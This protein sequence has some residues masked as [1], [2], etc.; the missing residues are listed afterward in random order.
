[1]SFDPDALPDVAIKVANLSKV[2]PIYERPHDRILQSIMPRL[3]KLAGIEVK[4]YHRAFKALDQVS[5]EVRRGQALGIIGRNGSG[6]STLLQ[7]ICGTLQPT[8]GGVELHG[9]VAALLELG[10]GFNP[11]FT[12]RENIHMSAAVLGMTADEIAGVYEDIVEFSGIDPVFIEQPVKIYSSGMYV[13]LAFAVIAHVNADVLVIDEALAVGDAVF[14]QKCMRFL[15]AFRERGTLLFVSH[16]TGSVINFCDSAVWLDRGEMRMAGDA[17]GVANAYLEYCAQQS[18]GESVKIRSIKRPASEVK[19]SRRVDE[20][21]KFAL[22]DNIANSDGWTSDHA[23]ILSAILTADDGSVLKVA[24]GGERVRLTIT[25]KAHG[26]I[27][28]PIIGFFVKDRLGQSLFGDNTF[29]HMP[30][31]LQVSAEEV[32]R[33]DFLF[34]LPM[35]PDGDYSMTVA[36]AE[37]DP[38]VNV[39]HHWVHDA[40]VIKVASTKLRY[41]LVGIPF[42]AV[43]MKVVE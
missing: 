37:G 42:E 41:G 12:G 8:S 40:V 19:Q 29:S 32:L 35:L 36:I 43:T 11:E 14:V 26:S 31:P 25:A 28:S 1:M 17:E 18:Y 27:S 34:D 15:R 23:E 3:Q 5:F 7:M 9:R 16:D 21:V 6:K 33:A 22:F 13:R 30:E 20:D 10:A 39:Q 24:K 2:Y 4:Q 38:W